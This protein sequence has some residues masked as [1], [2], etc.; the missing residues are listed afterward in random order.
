MYLHSFL[1][2]FPLN[3]KNQTAHVRVDSDSEPVKLVA[4][5][6]AI[7]VGLNE[8]SEDLGF[9]LESLPDLFVTPNESSNCSYMIS[10]L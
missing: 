8:K 2:E 3:L 4:L 6:K 5:F 7:Q 10:F 9:C 1:C